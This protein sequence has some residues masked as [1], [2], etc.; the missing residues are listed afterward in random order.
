MIDPKETI[1]EAKSIVS[2]H[3][4][5]RGIIE[6]P[7]PLVSLMAYLVV[8]IKEIY[9]IEWQQAMDTFEQL[10]LQYSTVSALALADRVL[11][12]KKSNIIPFDQFRGK[13]KLN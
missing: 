9:R 8:S 13:E 11:K 5:Q 7:E 12:D 6:I 4:K 10:C 2:E 3:L 1:E